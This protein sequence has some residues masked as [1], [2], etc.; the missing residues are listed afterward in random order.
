M[1]KFFA[2]LKGAAEDKTSKDDGIRRSLGG[3]PNE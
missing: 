3:P 2:W 1:A